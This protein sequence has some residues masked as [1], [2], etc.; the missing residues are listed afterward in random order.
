[1][2]FKHKYSQLARLLKIIVAT[3]FLF[4]FWEIE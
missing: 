2:L 1:M 4:N 3:I